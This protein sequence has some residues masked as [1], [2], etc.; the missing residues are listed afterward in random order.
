MS[1]LHDLFHEQGWEWVYAGP[2]ERSKIVNAL[3][4]D[5]GLMKRFL[6]AR[7]KEVESPVPAGL[8]AIWADH[9]AGF[10]MRA[11]RLDAIVETVR[12]A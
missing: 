7:E 11:A 9:E 8:E 6:L 1:D 4:E 3:R 5:G 2:E 12:R 10:P